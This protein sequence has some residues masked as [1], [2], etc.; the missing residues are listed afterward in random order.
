MGDLT[1]MADN[2]GYSPLHLS[3]YKN[4]LRI[5]D[6]LISHVQNRA[7]RE[8]HN[9]EAILSAWI[10]SQTQSDEGFTPLHFASFHGNMH[11]VR[12][13]IKRG[14]DP[15]LTNRHKINMLHVAAQGDQP[16]SL[17]YFKSIGV[18]INQT[19]SKNSTPLHWACYAGSESAVHYILAWNTDVNA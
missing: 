14:A 15:F 6:L 16:S 13:L 4:S 10:N 19:D 2:T 8:G 17:A 18:D 5:S 3:T 11:L 1:L 7:A 12:F 9:P